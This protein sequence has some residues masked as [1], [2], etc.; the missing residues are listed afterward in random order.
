[1]LYAS[2]AII[3]V[4]ISVI[5]RLQK[6]KKKMEQQ[7]KISFRIIFGFLLGCTKIIR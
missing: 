6:Y 3:L 2:L 4:I 7:K 5:N 1:M